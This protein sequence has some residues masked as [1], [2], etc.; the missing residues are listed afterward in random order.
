MKF[1]KLIVVLIVWF[2]VVLGLTFVWVYKL[3]SRSP[4]NTAIDITR[5]VLSPMFLFEFAAILA[6]AA[7]ISWRWA[8]R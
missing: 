4:A 7:W 3:G 8:V 5:V 2:V 1:V 6:L